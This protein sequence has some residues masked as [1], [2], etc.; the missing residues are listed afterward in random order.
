MSAPTGSVTE[1]PQ[2]AVVGSTPPSPR[3]DGDGRGA[4]RGA[5]QPDG[6]VT[7]SGGPPRQRQRRRAVGDPHDRRSEQGHVPGGTGRHQGGRVL[8]RER[9]L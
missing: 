4:G 2:S 3:A 1:A 5:L 6:D 8:R 7:R 9:L